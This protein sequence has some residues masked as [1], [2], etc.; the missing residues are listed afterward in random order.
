MAQK[1]WGVRM[2]YILCLCIVLFA[3][4]TWAQEP[5][6]TTNKPAEFPPRMNLP[7]GFDTAVE[8]EKVQCFG[9]QDYLTIIRIYKVYGSLYDWRLT[10]LGEIK[11]YKL[12]IASQQKTIDRQ[13]QVIKTL[14]NDREWLTLRLKQSE[15]IIMGKA[16]SSS[17]EKYVMWGVILVETVVIGIQAF[18]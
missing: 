12:A 9:S 8:G 15:E 18:R 1:A 4:S 13:D 3:V 2:R 17:M 16:G 7:A 5:K 6:K 10:A 11:G 14:K